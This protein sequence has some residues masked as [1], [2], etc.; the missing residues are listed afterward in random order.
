MYRYFIIPVVWALAILVLYSI[1]GF[2][3]SY[4]EPW[5]LLR[6]DKIAH[7]GLFAVMFLVLMVAFR[8]Q[9]S[10]RRLKFHARKFSL[11]L[12]LL[13]GAVL[14]FYQGAFFIER[15]SDLLDFIANSVGAF[16]G[17]LLFRILYGKELARV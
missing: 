6:L 16:L 11:I 2:D 10:Y 17:I 1:P 4:E 7:M 8:K 12:T 3:L 15:S 5:D 14:E 9:G 13:Y